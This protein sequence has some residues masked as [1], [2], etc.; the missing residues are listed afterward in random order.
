MTRRLRCVDLTL[1]KTKVIFLC[2]HNQAR[3]QMAEAFLRRYAGSYFDVYSGGY[4]P[5][6]IHP[7]AIQV[8]KE[9]GFDISNQQSK[10]LWQLAKNEHFGIVITL[11]KK[12][13]E[14]DCPTVPG[15]STRLYWNIEDPA[16]FEGT[17][18][19]KI[20]KFRAVRDQIQELV[21][22]FLKDRQIPIAG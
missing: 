7:F 9:I 13:E 16:S 18:E 12:G 20:A 1:T 19:Q 10:D 6:P 22:S 8:M 4:S 15:P 17:E 11:C 5:K 14:E 21:K 2:T 3:S